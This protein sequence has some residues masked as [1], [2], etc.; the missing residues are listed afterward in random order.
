[1]PRDALVCE[2]WNGRVPVAVHLA[3][4]ECTAH[5][6]PAPFLALL[7]RM[8]YLSQFETDIRSHFFEAIAPIEDGIWFEYHGAPLKWHL[9]IGVVFDSCCASQLRRV[10]APSPA[11]LPWSLTVHFQAFPEAVMP[12][13]RSLDALRT[14]FFHT[15][16]QSVWL[17]CGS[18]RPLTDMSKSEHASIW[19]AARQGTHLTV[20]YL[21]FS[22]LHSQ[23]SRAIA[24]LSENGSRLNAQAAWTCI[25]R[26]WHHFLQ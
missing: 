14:S 24:E 23:F 9:P 2:A 10:D 19:D 22:N 3:R 25:Q 21:A 4:D 13:C 26:R 12:R 6:P 1:M 17:R 20:T 16:K 18:A 7:P 5:E 11:A 15:L 8:S